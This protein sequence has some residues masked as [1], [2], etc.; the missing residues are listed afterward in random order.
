MTSTY[1]SLPVQLFFDQLDDDAFNGV[2]ARL[3]GYADEGPFAGQQYE[4]VFNAITQMLDSGTWTDGT[5][6]VTADVNSGLVNAGFDSLPDPL[7]PVNHPDASEDAW[8]SPGPPPLAIGVELTSAPDGSPLHTIVVRLDLD[9][10]SLTD[11]QKGVIQAR[12]RVPDTPGTE[13]AAYL[14]GLTAD[15][16][17]SLID[18][19]RSAYRPAYSYYVAHA[20]AAITRK[21][22][23]LTWAAAQPDATDPLPAHLMLRSNE[24]NDLR[25][26]A[27]TFDFNDNWREVKQHSK[28]TATVQSDLFQEGSLTTKLLLTGTWT[29]GVLPPDSRYFSRAELQAA[30]SQGFQQYFAAQSKTVFEPKR[31]RSTR[32]VPTSRPPCRS[33]RS[34]ATRVRPLPYSSKRSKT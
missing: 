4:S 33:G 16:L 8:T 12:G 19:L 10:P 32:A 13:I 18:Y 25:S 5:N 6:D 1:A 3:A 9:Q 31:R 21:R 7:P 26:V 2:V 30:Q 11:I 24:N 20:L 15:Q 34:C 22:D 27:F 28:Y 29:C 23:F 17:A 14:D